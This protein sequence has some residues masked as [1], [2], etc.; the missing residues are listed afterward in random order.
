[1]L[2]RV[3]FD[4][5]LVTQL[6]I[7]QLVNLAQPLNYSEINHIAEISIFAEV[8]D[9]ISPFERK[10]AYPQCSKVIVTLVGLHFTS[11]MKLRLIS[12][13]FQLGYIPR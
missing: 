6:S 2:V 11:S 13:H 4:L 5:M 8:L 7:K 1:M 3:S 12:F 10:Q 9:K